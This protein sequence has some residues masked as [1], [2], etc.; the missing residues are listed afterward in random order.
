MQRQD[1]VTKSRGQIPSQFVKESEQHFQKINLT[2]HCLSLP[3]KVLRPGDHE[4]EDK[5]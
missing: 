1:E 3:F 2:T 4:I 5:G